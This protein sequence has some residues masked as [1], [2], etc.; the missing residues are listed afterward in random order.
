MYGKIIKS[1]ECVLIGFFVFPAFADFISS[2]SFLLSSVIPRVSERLCLELN[3]TN[4][5]SS[6][7]LSNSSFDNPRYRN[8]LT[9]LLIL[10]L[11]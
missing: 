10:P 8:S 5:F 9:I 1:L 6:D 7:M 4:N 3:I 2:I 11:Y